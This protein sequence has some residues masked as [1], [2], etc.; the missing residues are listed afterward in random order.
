MTKYRLAGS[1]K[2]VIPPNSTEIN[3]WVTAN[4]IV[5]RFLSRKALQAV[6]NHY[7]LLQPVQIHVRQP[8]NLILC[9]VLKVHIDSRTL[10]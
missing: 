7:Q 4:V 8:T 10:I 3:S 1:G 5:P 9:C 6:R 2:H